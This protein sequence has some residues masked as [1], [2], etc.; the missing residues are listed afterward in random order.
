MRLRATRLTAVAHAARIAA[1]GSPAWS[2]DTAW[3][4]SSEQGMWYDPSDLSTMF[5]DSAGTTPVTAVEQPVGRI[6]DKSGRGNHATQ[7]TS[8]ARPTLRNRYNLLTQT[9]DLT[10]AVW[11]RT[12]AAPS[13]QGG[14]G[15]HK[16]VPTV[17]SGVHGISNSTPLLSF[18]VITVEA[19]AAELSVIAIGE[20]AQTGNFGSFNLSSGVA[21]FSGA[22]IKAVA[23]ADGWW[24]LS[25]KVFDAAL[26]AVGSF[27]IRVLPS[28]VSASNNPNSYA[29]DGDGT[30]GI[31]IRYPQV[32]QSS[33]AAAVFGASSFVAETYQP[34]T[35]ATSY[36]SDATKFPL[37]SD[38]GPDDFVTTA[39]GGGGTTGI[40]LVAGVRLNTLGA[41]RTIWSDAGTNTGY[42][43]RINS[44]NQVVFEAG[45]GSGYTSAIVA[46]AL[47]LG[48]RAVISAWHD[49]TT[50]NVQ[51]GS[52]TVAT[53]A[54]GT[55][56]AGTAGITIG[57]ANG[58]A[59]E[60][61]NGYLYDL[62]CVKDQAKTAD[63]ASAKSWLAALMGVTL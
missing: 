11:A 20:S 46:T 50:L 13:A 27:G 24:R 48:E 34:V 15:E 32:T 58:A 4:A 18:S 19:K 55:V 35:T 30:S 36:D 25:F 43:L 10:Q 45:N 14:L 1:G 28:N 26:A 54:M 38:Y 52:G 41:A 57:K 59:S 47:T 21:L 61:F 3:F 39:T 56:T 12:N 31:L 16:L 8:T 51:V 23:L 40:T 6:L 37:A 5:Q 44:S 60:F 49:G 42:R 29:W 22:R 7:A 17:A 2:P 9:Q 53:A 63:I 62:V 33:I